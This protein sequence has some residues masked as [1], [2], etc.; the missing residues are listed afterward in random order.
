[1]KRRTR[2]NSVN[3]SSSIASTGVMSSI[4]SSLGATNI[5]LSDAP[6]SSINAVQSDSSMDTTVVGTSDGDHSGHLNDITRSSSSSTNPAKSRPGGHPRKAVAARV[7]ECSYPG[8]TKAYTQ[9]HN[10]K[11]HERTGHTPIQKPKP[12]LCIISGCTK[13]FS[14][15]KS[16]AAHIRASHKEYKFKPFKC[17]QPGCQKAYTQLHNLRTHEKTVHMLDLSKKRIRNP[18]PNTGDAGGSKNSSG[19]QTDLAMGSSFGNG[20]YDDRS[21][22]GPSGMDERVNFPS[23]A[24]LSYES[25]GDLADYRVG[26]DG[27]AEDEDEGEDEEEELPEEDD[28][29]DEDYRDD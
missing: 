10:L 25:V 16:L 17:S 4:T 20:H 8:C 3:S 5:S 11:S 23:N 18:I 27:D 14:Q 9:L 12:F 13:A 19:M 26:M 15:R 22:H 2:T 21:D 24:G 6:S 28:D 1:P 29:D 7:F